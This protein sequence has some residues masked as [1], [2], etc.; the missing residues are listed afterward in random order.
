M[1]EATTFHGKHI[2]ISPLGGET[3]DHGEADLTIKPVTID[4]QTRVSVSV[5]NGPARREV[6]LDPADMADI[7]ETCI[8]VLNAELKT[9]E[10][11]KRL[12]I[13]REE[14]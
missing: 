8:S 12:A 1:T 2:E 4:G 10:I 11:D 5:G 3:I 9:R 13:H 7:A 14:A 6:I